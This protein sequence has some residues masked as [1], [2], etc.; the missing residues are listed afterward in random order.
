M[1]DSKIAAT[2]KE[3]GDIGNFTPGKISFESKPPNSPDTNICDV[4]LLHV[5]SKE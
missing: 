2:I 1:N 3:L 5:G 4:S